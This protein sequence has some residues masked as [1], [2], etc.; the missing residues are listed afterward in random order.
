MNQEFKEF[1][2]R[3]C[4]EL[5]KHEEVSVKLDILNVQIILKF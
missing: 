5:R 1:V 3:K 4:E 2:A